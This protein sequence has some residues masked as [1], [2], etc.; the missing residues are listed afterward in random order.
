MGVGASSRMAIRLLMEQ[1]VP[2]GEGEKKRI[3]AALVHRKVKA[4]Y[5]QMNIPRRVSF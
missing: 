4:Q 1:G 3:D 5:R 2:F